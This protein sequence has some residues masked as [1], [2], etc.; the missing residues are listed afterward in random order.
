VSESLCVLYVALTRAVHALHMIIPPS[1]PNERNLPRSHL[2][3]LRAALTD[4]G[5]APPDQALYSLGDAEW[6]RRPAGQAVAAPAS[7]RTEVTK[8][9]PPIR[10]QLKAPSGKPSRGWE[11]ARPSG[12]EG[13]SLV[14]ADQVLRGGT[15]RAFL[16]GQVIHA[17]FEQ[18]RWLEDGI[19]DQATLRG[20]AEDVRVREGGGRVDL[21]AWMR[22]F[23]DMLQRPV[24]AKALSRGRYQ[25]PRAAGFPAA[26]AARLHD[27]SLNV[28]NEQAFACRDGNRLFTGFVARLVLFEQNGRVVAAEIIDFKTDV[29][30]AGD[31]RQVA[32]K[33]AFYTPQLQAYRSAVADMTAL[34]PACVLAQL[35]FV[36]PG[37]LRRVA[38]DA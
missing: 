26:V 20:V 18:I 11:R 16:R 27:A 35:L 19:P 23:L 24:V 36:G 12:L 17:W 37:L 3:L 1:S 13:G 4:G 22:E 38:E 32:E 25:Q 5:A 21:D 28:H 29:L 30:D 8:E 10:I 14:S 34:D 31:S 6:Y 33:V 7:P 15:A 2:G 9:G